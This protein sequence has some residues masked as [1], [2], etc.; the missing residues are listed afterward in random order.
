[1]KFEVSIPF[2]SGHAFL[3]GV[4]MEERWQRIMYLSPSNRGT[5]SYLVE[6]A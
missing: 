4:C 1:M 2:Q 5:P 6:E 3:R